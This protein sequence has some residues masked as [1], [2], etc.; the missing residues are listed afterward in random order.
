MPG[1]IA[2]VLF[3]GQIGANVNQTLP[4][5]ITELIPTGL[6]GLI[7]AAV[8]AALMSA[9]SAALNSS[10]TLVAIDIVKR[11]RPRI[12]DTSLVAVGR[13]SSVA[14]MLLAVVW[15][16]QG[17]RFSS[18][19][20]AVNIIAAYLSPPIT[21][22]FL[23]G[24]FWRRGTKEASVVTLLVGLLMGTVAFLVDLPAFGNVKL[25]TD[26]LG[27]PFMM[28]AWWMFCIC[29]ALFVVV[30]LLTERPTPAQVD[31]LTWSNPVAVLF[32]SPVKTVADPRILAGLLF[33]VMVALYCLFR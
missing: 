6:R 7:A 16:T 23:F 2:Y 8:L 14:I 18:I 9:I 4:V 19:F 31:G 10:G 15:S 1:V 5:L 29:S 17:G 22:V 12:S 28:Q 13:V 21:T 33:L 26:R 27:I 3:R 32:G 25:I 24:V 11:L 30:S 20:A